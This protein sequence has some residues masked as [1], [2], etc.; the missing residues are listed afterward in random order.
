MYNGL[1]I[2]RRVGEW[3]EKLTEPSPY[4][5]ETTQRQD[6]RLLSALVLAFTIFV[7]FSGMMQLLYP[8]ENNLILVTVLVVSIAILLAT[9]G[10]SRTRYI[11]AACWLFI[12]L[13]FVVVLW[14]VY[15]ELAP[16]S[17]P[18]T[19]I[20]LVITVLAATLAF[21]MGGALVIGLLVIFTSAGVMF[22][23]Y[24][25]EI[26]TFGLLH[27]IIML[28]GTL[29]ISGLVRRQ[30]Q[31]QIAAQAAALA[32]ERNLLRTVI[33]SL[34]DSIY[35]K[36]RE[37]RFTLVNHHV[38]KGTGLS[39]AEV[40]GRSDLE[41]A[42]REFW[43]KT[44]AQELEVLVTGVPI[45]NEENHFIDHNGSA[46]WVLVTKV[47][48]HDKAGRI[49]GLVG[50]NRNIN[51]RK[52]VELALERER[53]LLRT[54]IDSLPDPVYVKDT[55]SRF[56]L[57]NQRVINDHHMA[58]EKDLLGKNDLDLIG[59]IAWNVTRPEDVEIMQTGI[60]V[61]N[62]E[63]SGLKGE[64]ERR[65]WL[66]T[67][68]PLRDHEGNIIGLVGIDRDITELKKIQIKLTEEHNLFNTVIN[69][70]PDPLYVKDTE[71]R[72]VML[73]RSGYEQQGYSSA[74][75]M[76]GKSDR[77]LLGE[78]VWRSTRPE[79][80][81]IM[82]SG[83][84][85]VNL[86][87]SWVRS[88]GERS[89]WLVTK[90]PLY[91]SSGNITGL[92]GLDRDITDRKKIETALA[93]E[94]NLL[95]AIMDNVPDQIYLKD[96][97]SHFRIVNRPVLD[98]HGFAS[99]AQI[100]GKTDAEL[101]GQETG[102]RYKLLER[103]ILERGE[104]VIN[105]EKSY[106]ADGKERWVLIT[107]VPLRDP[108]GTIIGLVGVNRDITDRKIAEIQIQALVEELRQQS[109]MMD[110]VL[111]TT[112]D[113][114][115]MHDRDGRYLYS[116]PPALKA[117]GL[118]RAEVVGKTWRELGFPEA[119]GI[120]FERNLERVFEHGETVVSES[121][122]PTLDG[123][124][125]FES[126]LSP[127]HDLE[128]NVVS[129]VN[130]I[131]DIT[132]RKRMEETLRR[133][134]NLLRTIIESVPDPI[135]VKDRDSRFILANRAVWGGLGLP[136]AEAIVGKSDWDFMDAE[137]AN[138]YRQDELR[139]M[140]TRQSLINQEAEGHGPDGIHAV[141]LLTKV[142]LLDSDGEVIGLVGVNRSI[143][144]R[145]QIENEL[146]RERNLLLTLI[147][148][149]PECIYVKDRDLRFVLVNRATREMM[150]GLGMTD[151]IGKTDL[152][153][154]EPEEAQRYYDEE[155]RVL[156]TQQ[157]LVNREAQG[158]MLDGKPFYMLVTK[159]AV[160]DDDGEAVYVI[161]MN[162]DIT[163]YKQAETQLRYQAS[164][165]ESITDAV[166]STDLQ[167]RIISWNHGATELYG[168][169]PSEAIGNLMSDLVPMV[170]YDQTVQEMTGELYRTGHWR[171][172]F[173]QHTQ[174]GEE[175]N[176]LGSV[177]LV[178]DTD[179]EPIG[180]VTVN[181][182][183]T[184]RK[185]VEQQEMDL[186]LE[187]ARVNILKR[188]IG[189]MSHDLRN[190]L[191][192]IKV[193]LYLLRKLIDHPERRQHHLEILD[194]HV[195]RL[196]TM[197]DDLLNMSYLDQPTDEFNFRRENLVTLVREVVKQQQPLAARR[198]QQLEMETEEGIPEV[199]FDRLKFNRAITNLVTN[200]LNYTPRAGQVLVR[201]YRDA[202]HVA[203][204][205][206][207]NGIGIA[208]MDL[209]YIFDRFY[210][211]DKARRSDTGGMGV[212]LSIAQRIVQA[213][214]GE[215]RVTSKAGEGSTFTILLP[216]VIEA[217]Q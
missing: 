151:L 103:S 8:V 127:L 210:R 92:L 147:E 149:M 121:E 35:V 70:L 117:T 174:D 204:A 87:R 99:P 178:R 51:D 132:D 212:G 38:V 36:D 41:L 199:V 207:D 133:E 165:L 106:L 24:G 10:L 185:W 31:E 39:Y 49:V 144:E 6:A 211:A 195:L 58:R 5:R 13:I 63:R 71:S 148:N 142:P 162:H 118:S 101:F 112:P 190:P 164:L 140:E 60:P 74:E 61:F 189:D 116:S 14:M 72:I 32:E 213:H 12:V 78:G 91:D 192:T 34:P 66:T 167:S 76:I 177:S 88:N 157:P 125:Y 124:G 47:P 27:I 152:D 80:M 2:L 9:Y 172:E 194:S 54:V 170:G 126:I 166:I 68:A 159:V 23:L 85:L 56:L 119:V 90:V 111:S 146:A 139:L 79:D 77:E 182:D 191:A 216:L 137:N 37:S 42:G 129:A 20:Y 4:L 98:R 97:E 7:T 65:W 89:W 28:C 179:G 173:V 122:F 153:I 73:N 11:A 154:F 57:V 108:D 208:E 203:V 43:E 180:V 181:R 145:K 40:V 86:E 16:T 171:G 17:V 113:H 75:A 209:P 19:L 168:W 64:T 197:V 198:N 176:V 50:I 107:K 30:Q 29:L 105:Y 193:S 131:R 95:Q 201:V 22:A 214:G 135:Y 55:E 93:R 1:P 44:R 169:S 217:S 150:S 48:L 109:R 25:A 114:F 45:V 175:R 18:T 26:F 21:P 128:G 46:Q 196:E 94:R 206:Q 158:V 82:A 52:V 96:T 115:H 130:T 215:I 141:Y 187:R 3:F 188:F 110:E 69:S 53:N 84:P 160:L 33:E 120:V 202:H 81:H 155:M 200:A 134:R 205:I 136:N 161:G 156:Q 186:K 15:Y 184:E 67:K 143:T 100:I 59:E 83:E 102:E 104:S 123:I 183:I 163:E 138:H 62:V